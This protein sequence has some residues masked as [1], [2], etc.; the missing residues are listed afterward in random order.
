MNT[1][2]FFIINGRKDKSEIKPEVE[3]QIKENA[4]HLEDW[5]DTYDIYVTTG[6]GDATRFVRLYCDLHPN[7][8]VC[9]IACGGDGTINEV[10]SGLVGFQK[11]SM[12]VFNMCGNSDFIR[13]FPNR[14][15]KSFHDILAGK[16]EQIDII[17][18]ND[19]YS[20]NVAHI[21]FDADVTDFA[22]G[23]SKMGIKDPFQKGILRAILFSRYNKISITI[24]GEKIK[25]RHLLL[26]S[27]ANASWYGAGMNCAPR[28]SVIDGLIDVCILKPMLMLTFAKL[29]PIYT[30]GEHFTDKRFK[31]KLI[32]RQ[33]KHIAINAHG[34]LFNISLDG[35]VVPTTKVDINI[36]PKAIS[37][38]LPK[39]SVPAEQQ[40]R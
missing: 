34:E 19:N 25:L 31:K 21:G 39:E 1:K 10:A 32:Y 24:D 37:I 13:H 16:I 8:E 2:F 17:K 38:R 30:R 33:A 36:L 22:N 14:D 27:F 26:S 3:K 20:I 15:F 6:E 40:K 35:E 11:K 4:H 29:L 23:Y 12:S 5:H 28:A 7:E 18:A 9:F